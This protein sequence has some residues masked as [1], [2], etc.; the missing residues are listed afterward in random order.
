[1]QRLGKYPG[2]GKKIPAMN[3]I[4]FAVLILISCFAACKKSE[5][6]RI[7]TPYNGN[8]EFLGMDG[9]LGFTPSSSDTTIILTLGA[10]NS[11]MVSLN[12]YSLLQ[13]TFQVDSV[14]EEVILAFSNITQPYG[15]TITGLG[16]GQSNDS[17]NFT[18]IGQLTLFQNN[19][20][21]I[22]GDTLILV[23]SPTFGF[24][25]QSSVFKHL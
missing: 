23:Q 19:A 21:H 11:Y 18:I 24:A 6:A 8:W 3:R 7:Y 20:T 14:S 12:G 9:P 5:V 15:S 17:A 16:I 4:L 22:L 2:H 13:G 25:T 1:M 10:P